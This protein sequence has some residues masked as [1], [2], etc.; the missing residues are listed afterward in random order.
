MK[1]LMAIIVSVLITG[2][3][4]PAAAPC[5]S[6]SN[7]A[8]VKEL[9][10]LKDRIGQLEKELV[11][12]DKEMEVLKEQTSHIAGHP[13][14]RLP[15]RI[16]EAKEALGLSDRIELSGVIEVEMGSE[17]H[18]V[19]Y[20]GTSNTDK[21]RDDDLTLATVEIGVDTDI[22][23]Y[24][25]GHLL[26]LYEEDE[27]EDRL[28][29][30][31]GTIQI[32]GVEETCG[33]Y[34]LAGKYYPHFGELNSWFVSDSLNLEIF[35]IRE[36]AVQI[37]CEKEWFTAGIGAFHGDIQETGED[38][39]RI[40]G[41]FADASFHNPEDTLGGIS[42]LLGASYLSNL[43]DTDT[44]QDEDGADGNQ[45]EDYVDGIAAYLVAEYGQFSLGAEYITALDD[46][47]EG[48]M[49][50]AVNRNGS[51]R[52]TE[53][54]AWNIEFAFRPVDELQFAVKYEGTNDMFGL[55]PEEQYGGV[56]SWALFD[57][58]VLSAEYLHGE[59]DRNN[60][61]ADGQ[62]EDDRDVFTMQLAVEF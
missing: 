32:G 9:G 21:F 3:F 12:K 47:N 55:F 18:R 29:I 43:A 35:E 15:L 51:A 5:E 39:S 48:E 2:I 40:K 34:V 54:E 11:E 17:T 52:S 33:F 31:E 38:E 8:I 1:K 56:V 26:F 28:R 36:S 57:Q 60:Q 25:K 41:F 42:L 37:G 10:T 23:K 59:Y 30:D 20:P 44:L 19:K 16:Q 6:M 50:Y 49:A 7:E 27:D 62:I 58:T 24:T 45:I 22:N 13:E 4:V 14:E 53:P 61:N 46:F